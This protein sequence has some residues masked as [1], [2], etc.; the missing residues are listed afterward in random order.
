MERVEARKVAEPE[1]VRTGIYSYI[2]EQVDPRLQ[3]QVF[4]TYIANEY[5]RLVGSICINQLNLASVCVCEREK[6]HVNPANRHRWSSCGR[7]V[8]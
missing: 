5:Q 1:I 3:E 6:E 4:S 7:G 2:Y 8:N